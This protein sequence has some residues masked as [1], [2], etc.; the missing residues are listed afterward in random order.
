VASVASCAKVV[1]IQPQV[2]PLNDRDLMVGVQVAVAA[3]VAEAQF[4]QHS[5][6]RRITQPEAPT[7]RDDRWFPPAVD[8]PPTV[9]LEAQDPQPAVIGIV[10]TLGR[11]AP[12]FVMSSLSNSAV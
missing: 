10:A 3:I 1:E 8:A 7:V 9:P 4:G 11:R 5:V 6:R 2:R 12:L